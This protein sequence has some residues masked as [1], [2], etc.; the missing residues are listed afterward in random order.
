MI[1]EM[2]SLGAQGCVLLEDPN[3]YQRFVFQP[4]DGLVLLDIPPEYFQALLFKGELPQ[5]TVSYH[6]AFSAKD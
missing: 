3:Y 6:E 4:K 5:G 2:K 1:D